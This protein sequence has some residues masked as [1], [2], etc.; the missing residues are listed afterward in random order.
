MV[1]LITSALVETLTKHMFGNYLEQRDQIEIGG[2]PSWYMMPVDDEMCAF[3]HKKG[4][5]DYIDR[6]KEKS[7]FKLKRKIDDTIEIVIYDNLKNIKNEKE[8]A[9][10]N[11]FKKD[12]D[13]P[14]F[15]KKNVRYSR[16]SYEDEINTTFVRACIPKTTIISYQ[17]ERLKKIK[18][19]VLNV[20]VNNAFDDMEREQTKTTGYKDPNDPFS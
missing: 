16:V 11:Q 2:A 1:L 14:V 9:V 4:S 6:V 7:S 8:K 19:E 5:M 3:A 12:I 15:I 17:E 20:K 18:N 10:V 13:L